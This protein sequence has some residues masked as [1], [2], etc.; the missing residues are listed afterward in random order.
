M[1]K[2]RPLCHLKWLLIKVSCKLTPPPQNTDFDDL[3]TIL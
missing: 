3:A 2:F 1:Q